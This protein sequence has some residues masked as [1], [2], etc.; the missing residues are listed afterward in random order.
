MNAKNCCLLL[1]V[2][3]LAASA[4]SVSGQSP[5]ADPVDQTA[6][7]YLTLPLNGDTGKDP[8]GSILKRYSVPFAE[9]VLP[10]DQGGSAQVPVGGLAERIFL[11]GMTSA[12]EA[13]VEAD[14]IVY[15]M[16]FKSGDRSIPVNGWRDP[17]DYSC[18]FFIGDEVGRI[19]L[20]YADGTTQVYPV[21]FGEGVWFGHAFYFYHEPFPTD[22]NLQKA[23]AAA[24]RLYPPE[25][26][27]DGNYLAV[28]V[29]EH[30]PIRSITVDNSPAKQGSLII[31]GIT[32]ESRETTGISA[33][34]SFARP[35][36]PPELERFVKEKALLPQGEEKSLS[37]QRLNDL[38]L[39]LY[40]SD[41]EY[42]AHVA[43]SSPT[44]YSGPQ[45][46]FGGN[47][48]AE[49]LSN[50]FRYNVEDILDKID[51]EGMYHTSTK[52]AL[53]WGSYRAFGT[54]RWKVG[55]YYDVAFARDM[56]RSLQEI[57]E[58]GYTDA[59]ARAVDYSLQKARLYQTD[60][61]LKYN[62]TALPPH[63]GQLVNRPNP[64]SFEN[65]GHGL[66]SLAIYKLWQRLPDRDQWLRS[67]WTDVKAAGDWIL[68]QFDHPE[69]S[70][71][72]DGLLHTTG[73]S[74]NGDGYSVYPDA[75]C[76][77]ALRA[78]AQ[79]ADSIGEAGSAAKWRSRAD[80][81]SKAITEHYV[82]S[83]A[84]YGRVWTLDHANW[85]HKST[86]LGPL[87]FQAD[88]WGFAPEDSNPE[89]RQINEATYQRLI[90]TYKPSQPFG[91]YGQSMGYG[92]GFVSQ[93]A[94]LLD[95]LHDATV[96][97]DWAAKQIYDPRFG[98]FIVPEGTQIDPT[99]KFWFRM[100]DQGNG[101]QEAEIVKTLRLIIGVDD[102]QPA[103]LQLFPRMPYDWNEIAVKKYPLVF[104]SSGKL[105]N[106]SLTYRL[107]RSSNGMDLSISS[108]KDLG[109]VAIRL[110]PFENR[111]ETSSV[112][113]NGRTPFGT[114]VEPSG[115][116]WWVRFKMPVN[117]ARQ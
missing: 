82:I 95:R 6:A 109:Q 13:S 106:A 12:K 46:T 69:I 87:I 114:A 26:L 52:D 104:E 58:L 99:G 117:Q 49:I 96:M 70:G 111:P 62:D 65:D 40:S 73:E 84:T 63:W 39:A 36:P 113:V 20:N 108:D 107:G 24:L 79:M 88:T 48:S 60:P 77:E 97:I 91:F 31:K 116:S 21:R 7:K 32:L 76:M 57:A 78:L 54:F 18:R 4:R 16:P 59:V 98:F 11:L 30:K 105:E 100:G 81:M 89:W 37:E 94:L 23:F 115:D 83:D 22:A 86:V 67:H 61:K 14:R 102:T 38:T 112:R 42:P 44:G 53:S 43:A 110:G 15:S 19:R 45:V 92:Q 41:R 29:P 35:V 103:R 72:R 27:A 68:W 85:T 28:I 10:L 64:R 51:A 66:T 80:Q 1:F 9:G 101:V 55:A 33:S 56:G 50:A 8:N 71:A 90:D 17:R 47:I 25:P 74:A 5:T 3:M 75:V 93:S 2:A 34:A